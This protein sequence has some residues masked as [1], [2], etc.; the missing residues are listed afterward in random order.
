MIT[1]TS[2]TGWDPAL[3]QGS[4]NRR[5]ETSSEAMGTAQENTMAEKCVAF[6][7]QNCSSVIRRA[8]TPS[9]EQGVTGW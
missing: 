4:R 5:K 1:E 7:N 3:S 9:A 6:L 2:W 8:G